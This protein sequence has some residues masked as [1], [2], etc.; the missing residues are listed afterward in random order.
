MYTHAPGCMEHKPHVHNTWSKCYPEYT[1]TVGV[2]H[3]TGCG[4]TQN[5]D[6]AQT[7]TWYTCAG[8]PVAHSTWVHIT[9]KCLWPIAHAYTMEALRAPGVG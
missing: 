3:D 7:D 2:R 8:L 6:T 1:Y 5:V 9:T 4:H